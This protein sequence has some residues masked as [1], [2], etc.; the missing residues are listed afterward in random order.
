MVVCR[1][2]MTLQDVLT[3]LDANHAPFQGGHAHAGILT[4]ARNTVE[5][6]RPFIEDLRGRYPAYVVRLTGLSLGAGASFRADFPSCYLNPPMLRHCS[7]CYYI[8][9]RAVSDNA[10]QVL[11]FRLSGS[12]DSRCLLRSSL[13][14]SCMNVCVFDAHRWLPARQQRG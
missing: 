8:I 6:V 11:C 9:T 10:N 12:C 4:S 3:D 1:A 5:K 14:C 7:Y 2:T 13:P